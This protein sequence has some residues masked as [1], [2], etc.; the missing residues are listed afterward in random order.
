MISETVTLTL[1]RC[2]TVRQQGY[3]IFEQIDVLGPSVPRDH[4][5]QAEAAYPFGKGIVD[6]PAQ[7]KFQFP[8]VPRKA[9]AIKVFDGV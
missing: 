8:K 7:D 1:S 5:S 9:I 4:V 2:F 3:T 6:G